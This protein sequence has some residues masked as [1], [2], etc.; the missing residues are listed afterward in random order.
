MKNETALHL[1]GSQSV[2][3]GSFQNGPYR[4][5]HTAVPSSARQGA[6][7]LQAGD[8][9]AAALVSSTS[10]PLPVI[11]TYVPLQLWPVSGDT[12]HLKGLCL[13]S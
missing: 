3:N 10:S 12:R 11:M 6:S 7:A 13:V 9:A 5:D 1:T 2:R 8:S 4:A